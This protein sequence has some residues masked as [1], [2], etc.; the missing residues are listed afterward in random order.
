M[1]DEK[2]DKKEVF[3]ERELK[4]SE[5]NSLRDAASVSATAGFGDSYINAYAIALK[6][7][8]ATIGL[9]TSLP[10]LIAPISQL[11]TS[12]AMETNSRKKI[13]AY[14]ILYQSLLWIPIIG[15]S[16]FFLK[17]F[18]FSP[19]IL[20]FFYT[21]YIAFGNF[22]APAWSSWIGDIIE[23]EKTGKFFGQRNSVGSITTLIALLM[24]G[25]ILDF[26]R[27][28]SNQENYWLFIGFGIIFFLAMSFRLLSRHFVLKQH[29]PEFKFKKESYFSFID[30]IKA[31]PDRNYGRFAIYIALIVL[32]TNIAGP[33]YGIYMLRELKFSYIQFMLMMVSSVSA[34]L[35]FTR[36]WGNFSDLYGKVNTLRISSLFIPLLCFLWP[37]SILIS[38]PWKFYFLLTTS[39][40]GGAAWAGFNLAAGTFVYDAA[41]PEKRSLCVAYSNVINGFGVFVGSTIGSLLIQYLRISF[42]N[43]IMLVSLISGIA[44]YVVSYLMIPTIKEVKIIEGKPDWKEI[45]LAG[46]LFNF[47]ILI[48]NTLISEGKRIS[49]ILT[50]K[51]K[52]R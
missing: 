15:V 47:P 23:K 18:G 10:N 42:M 4:K 28:K 32:A 40:I 41:R 52:R 24:G 44:R 51:R 5:E 33:Y 16:F 35:L 27:W 49:G 2:I 1:E 6:A 39:F 20:V 46:Q 38:S 3:S 25:F 7:A 48:H 14:S 19:I 21:I 17:G 30:F 12:K 26:F 29:E 13:F 50:K 22:A 36:L 34:T 45:P 43:V 37:I 9:L 8:P 11:F 31:A